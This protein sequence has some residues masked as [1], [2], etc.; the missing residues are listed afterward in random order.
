MDNPKKLA[1][2]GAH[3]E[4]KQNKNTTQYVLDTTIRKQM[5]YYY[6]VLSWLI[7]VWLKDTPTSYINC[8]PV[9]GHV[10]KWTIRWPH[11]DKLIQNLKVVTLENV[12][13]LIA[14]VKDLN[15]KKILGSVYVRHN[16]VLC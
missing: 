2:K 14:N 12:Y 6:L 10:S 3:G 15:T 4:E 5:N 16:S 9:R 11:V 13:N 8:L 1:T 7:S